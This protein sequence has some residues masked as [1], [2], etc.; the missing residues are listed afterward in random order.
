[1]RLRGV[2]D[3]IKAAVQKWSSDNAARLGAA[4]SYYT[5]FAIPPLF[6][7][8]I[9]VASLVLDPQT[10]RSGLFTEVGGLIGEKGAHAIESA[11]NASNPQAKGLFASVLA[12]GA[13]ILTATGLFIELQ[14]DLNTIWGVQQKPGKGVWTFIK[15][16]L[17]SFAMV[18]TIG[19]LLMVSLVVSAAVAAVGKYFSSLIPGV[20]VLSHILDIC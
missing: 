18:V 8:I 3:V 2:W 20:S 1:M 19:F 5:I 7:I 16:R 14:S 13:L 6:I 12:V 17:L 4:L 10:V 15:T 11:L 9:Y